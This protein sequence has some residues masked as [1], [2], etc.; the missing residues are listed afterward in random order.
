MFSY[1]LQ[2][3]VFPVLWTFCNP[4]L[5]AFKVTFPRVSKSLCHSPKLGSLLWPLELSQQCKNIFGMTIVQFVGCLL[6]SSIVELIATSSKWTYATCH[7]SLVCFC[8]SPCPRSRSLLTRASAGDTQTLKGRSGS[9][10][11]GGHCSF[12]WVL[13]ITRFCLIRLSI[14]GGSE[15]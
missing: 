4:I 12:P 5:L 7:T 15:I 14:S 11:C 13:M 6:G 3:S 9:V 10:S 8:Q 1:A 2:E